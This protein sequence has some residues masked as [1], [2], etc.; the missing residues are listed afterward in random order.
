MGAAVGILFDEA[1]D[2]RSRFD[3]TDSRFEMMSNT[4]VEVISDAIAE[5][6]LRNVGLFSSHE[7]YK[8][9]AGGVKPRFQLAMNLSSGITDRWRYAQGPMSLELLQIPYSGSSMFSILMC[10]DKHR[11]KAVCRETVKTPESIL[12]DSSRLQLVKHLKESM[13][14]AILKPNFEGGSVGVD[15][16]A[17]VSN[18]QEAEKR[19]EMQLKSYPEGILVEKFVAG[20]EVTVVIVGNGAERQIFPLALAKRDGKSLPD[21]FVRTQ[22]EKSDAFATGDRTW[23]SL[24]ETHGKEVHNSVVEA[25]NCVASSLDLLDLARLDFRLTSNGDALFIEAN[26]QPTFV[27]GNTSLFRCNELLF[28]DSLGLEKAY[29]QAAVNRT[30]AI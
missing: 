6:G 24:Q 18:A 30:L 15:E 7:L 26:A 12:I 25:A 9:I 13:F 10:R 17:I 29:V 3:G 1:Q 8:T 4:S 16:K 20:T 21:D 14:P 28:K 2:V 23:F 19:I 27:P 11:C 5:L 22:A